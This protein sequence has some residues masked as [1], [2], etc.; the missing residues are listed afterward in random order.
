M[1]IVTVGID[2]A[3][4]VFAVHGVEET[5][6]PVLAY[7]NVSRA[8]LLELIAAVTP[9]RI[10]IKA[11]LRGS[12]SLP[13][14]FVLIKNE[15]QQSQLMVHRA[16][17]GFIEQRIA[18]RNRIPDLLCELGLVLPLKGATVQTQAH[19]Y[20]EDLFG[21]CNTVVYDMLRE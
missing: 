16:R 12:D 17:Q 20:P 3:K 5:G 4:N 1:A 14:A 19:Q 2:P 7:T 11:C 15:E 10:G 18:T 13:Y 21:W 8:K 9:C 6:R